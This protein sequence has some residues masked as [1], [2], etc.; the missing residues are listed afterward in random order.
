M[1]AHACDNVESEHPARRAFQCG[2]GAIGYEIPSMDDWYL[3]FARVEAGPVEVIFTQLASIEAALHGQAANRFRVACI[4]PFEVRIGHVQ[5]A[6]RTRQADFHRLARNF[7][8]IKRAVTDP[9]R[10][11]RR[12]DACM[13]ANTRNAR[14]P[15]RCRRTVP[16]GIVTENVFDRI[17]GAHRRPAVAE[18]GPRRVVLAKRSLPPGSGAS[19]DH[20]AEDF[21]DL[22]MH[23][24]FVVVI[25]VREHPFDEI[26]Q[27]RQLG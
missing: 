15:H 7:Q 27:Y 17:P 22:P 3:L 19:I 21:A 2:L 13:C 14:I 1:I 12:R 9:L 10:S 24:H 6:Y 18:T 8:I 23:P 25:A 20:C 16:R 4:H 11:V 5:N 26:S